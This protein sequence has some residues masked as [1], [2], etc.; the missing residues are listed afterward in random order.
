[1]DDKGYDL[2]REGE[3]ESPYRVAGGGI[4]LDQ[5]FDRGFVQMA[6]DRKEKC[7]YGLPHYHC[8]IC[9]NQ[10]N[11]DEKRRDY[12]PCCSLACIKS[13]NQ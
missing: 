8:K 1:M 10:V 9:G 3:N 11:S 6:C 2:Y 4:I 5:D 12:H 7:G 13:Y